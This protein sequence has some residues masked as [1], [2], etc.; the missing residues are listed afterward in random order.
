MFNCGKDDVCQY[1]N[2]TKFSVI[3]FLGKTTPDLQ[4]KVHREDLDKLAVTTTITPSTTTTKTTTTTTTS[5][6]TTTTKEPGE[7]NKIIIIMY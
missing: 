5:P 1:A 3:H 7:N 2:D 4:G 6:T